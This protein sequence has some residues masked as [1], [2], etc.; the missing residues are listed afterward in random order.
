MKSVFISHSSKDAVVACSVVSCLEREGISVWIAPR[1][2][3]AGSNYG[4][5]IV[6][7]IRESAILVLIFTKKSN[8]SPAVFRE[9][10]KA[11]EDKKVIIPLRIE[12]VPVSD[13]LS[14]YLSGLHWLDAVHKQKNVEKLV[15]SIKQV[16]QNKG[17]E[18]HIAPQLSQIS[19]TAQPSKTQSQA[20][21]GAKT[22]CHLCGSERKHKAV[23]CTKCGASLIAATESV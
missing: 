7:G 10:Q 11:F 5:S 16:L 6:R 14:F 8:E 23:F 9:V 1:D 21:D 4:A 3:P 2:I 12:N 19:E 22:V 20:S 13:D 17:T 18:V 15:R